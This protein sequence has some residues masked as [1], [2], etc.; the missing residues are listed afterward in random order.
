MFSSVLSSANLEAIYKVLTHS[1]TFFTLVTLYIL[2]SQHA[3]KLWCCQ[4]GSC[5]SLCSSHIDL[6]LSLSLSPFKLLLRIIKAILIQAF[7]IIQRDLKEH[8]VDDLV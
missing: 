3:N 6:A 4:M 8:S 5:V 2:Q 1:L 7:Q